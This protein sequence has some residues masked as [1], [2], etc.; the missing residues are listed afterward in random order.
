MKVSGT[1]NGIDLELRLDEGCWLKADTEDENNRAIAAVNSLP[2]LQFRRLSPTQPTSNTFIKELQ[3]IVQLS[4]YL[5]EYWKWAFET[6]LP[7]DMAFL[8][9]DES[10]KLTPNSLLGLMYRIEQKQLVVDILA[11]LLMYAQR[12]TEYEP[13]LGELVQTV[14]TYIANSAGVTTQATQEEMEAL[15]SE[16][17]PSKYAELEKKAYERGFMANF[18]RL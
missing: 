7:T 16:T 13:T 4:S 10:S 1:F 15:L 12:L 2:F 9:S 17:D 11:V 6:D 14:G 8:D 18:G 5:Q 3:S